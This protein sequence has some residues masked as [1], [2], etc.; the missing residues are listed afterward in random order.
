MG[1]KM[2]NVSQWSKNASFDD[3]EVQAVVSLMT[4]QIAKKD[5]EVEELRLRLAVQ[6]ENCH[7][8]GRKVH[9]LYTVIDRLSAERDALR[10]ERELLLRT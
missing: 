5:R 1:M 9:S 4:G 2:E 7:L 8:L 10:Q 6:R 3:P